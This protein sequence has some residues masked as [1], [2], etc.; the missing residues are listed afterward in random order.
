MM[1]VKISVVPR[2]PPPGLFLTNLLADIIAKE[3]WA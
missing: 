2:F 3:T 1:S